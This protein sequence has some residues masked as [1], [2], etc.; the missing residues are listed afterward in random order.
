MTRFVRY[1]LF[2]VCTAQAFFAVAFFLQWPIAVNV[3]PYAGTTP[4]TF[5]FISSIFAAAAASTLW[6]VATEN[7]GALAGIGLDYLVILLPVAIL[8]FQ[9]A[10]SG[11]DSRMTAYGIA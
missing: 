2:V 1:L 7:Y 9:L 3:W 11:G 6:A 4:L 8:S 10:A 5:I